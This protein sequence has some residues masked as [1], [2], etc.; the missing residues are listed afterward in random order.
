M[1]FRTAIRIS[2]L[3]AFAAL[4]A[5]A[6]A[7]AVKRRAFVTSVSGSGNLSSWPDAGGNVGLAAGDAICRARAAA[8][9]LPNANT[10]RA[11]LSSDSTDAYCHV[12][13]LSG[14]KGACVGGAGDAAGPWYL[15]N[16]TAIV[17]GDLDA[18]TGTERVIFR[19]VMWTES[20]S[21][22]G[23]ADGEVWTG[24]ASDGTGIGG[25][26]SAWTSTVGTAVYGH[27]HASAAAW[28]GANSGAC[29]QSRR[30]LCLEPG[31]SEPPVEFWSPAALV[32]TT[33]AWGKSELATWTEAGGATGILAGDAICRN[34]AAA[35]HLPAP[36]SFV[37][38][39]S[40]DAVN[41]VDRVTTNGP[42]SRIDGFWVASSKPQLVDGATS[43]SIH[44]DE[45]GHYLASPQ[46]T[47]TGTLG[48]GLWSGLDCEAWTEGDGGAVVTYGHPSFALSEAWTERG[49]MGCSSM[50]RLY[51]ISNVVT[52]FWDGFDL[53][54]DTS[55]WS[56][57]TP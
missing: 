18:L 38:W 14:S 26:C 54:G 22:V 55:R 15:A 1:S 34:L 4:L 50:G 24:T 29:T 35:A 8:A 32:F 57:V 10:Y 5:V 9:A 33:S 49:V 7:A 46:W 56:S 23:Y 51:C 41:A 48:S 42:F 17:T 31:T 28:T 39:L 11:W 25:N 37:A 47:W 30:L 36:T 21:D 12:K 19:P 44:Q 6:P 45:T 3:V 13:G 40:T 27:A 20:G 52:L 16:G 43:N 53:T 2:A